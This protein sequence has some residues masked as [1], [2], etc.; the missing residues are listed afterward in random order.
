MKK[1]NFILLLLTT[2]SGISIAQDEVY[3]TRNANLQVHGEFNEKSL[4]GS[5]K[6]LGITLDYETTE[7]ILKLKLNDLTFSSD[8]LNEVIL[9][10]H[11]E[12]EFKGTLSLEHINTD[13]HPPQKFTIEGWV[14]IGN[15]KKKIE[16]KGELHH[17]DQSGDFAC[18]L[19]MTIHLDLN[20]FNIKIP[21]LE[22]EMEVVIKQ[23]LLK[24]DKN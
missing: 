5:T 15:E 13:D 17:I 11:T 22:N 2:I 20:D 21:K 19:G 10:Q 23:A 3:Y 18:M 9:K 7:I 4:H 1:L 6:Q 12:L 24:I 16:G 8:S 14:E